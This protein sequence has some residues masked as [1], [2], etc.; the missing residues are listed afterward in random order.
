MIIKFE[1]GTTIEVKPSCV[2][3]A[4]VDAVKR[5][6]KEK[7]ATVTSV[8]IFSGERESEDPRGIIKSYGLLK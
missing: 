4:A 8:T 3:D 2:V 1:D 6:I 5:L 7:G